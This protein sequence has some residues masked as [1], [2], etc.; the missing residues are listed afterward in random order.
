MSGSGTGTPASGASGTV[1]LADVERSLAQLVGPYRR[2]TV[3][4]GDAG[5]MII[6]S[7]ISN[8]ENTEWENLYLLRRGKKSD[9][10][11][12]AGFT[13]VDR[14]R[15]VKEQEA[16][17][18]TLTPDRN[19]TTSPV[20][21]E[22]IEL[23]HFDPDNELRPAAQAGLWRCFF[24][25]RA[26]VTLPSAAAERNL[27]TL[28][29]WLR[30]TTRVKAIEYLASGAISLPAPVSWF[31]PFTS[32]GDVWLKAAPDPY[33]QQV[34]V[35][36]R[37]PVASYVNGTTNMAGPTLDDDELVG[38]TEE[39]R[40]YAAAGHIEAWRLFADRMASAAREGNRASRQDAADEFTRLAGG[41]A[42]KQ[43][44]TYGFAQPFGLGSQSV[45]VN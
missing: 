33:P 8:V 24:E 34:Y 41:G 7:L 37:R 31:K 5:S 12:V 9:G 17:T 27:T 39:L 30:R 2:L 38:T 45:R 16:Q 18:G 29:P 1:T 28:L 3:A 11:S 19:W 32:A 36:A 26:A 44:R 15:L 4:S 14:V 22:L 25:D 20:A 35:T 40:Y 21:D 6:T 13:D 43:Q 10:T 23:H 42:V